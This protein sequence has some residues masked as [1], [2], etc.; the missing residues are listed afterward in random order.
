MS[1]F[2]GSNLWHLNSESARRL[3]SSWN[4]MIQ[5][6]FMNLPFGTHRF[7]LRELSDRPPLQQAL[8]KR[9]SKFCDQIKNSGKP[10]VLQ[11]FHKQK[12]DSRSSFG[13]NYKDI[14]IYKKELT[15]YLTPE[16]DKWKVPVIKELLEVMDKKS[17]ISDFSTDE[18]RCFLAD[19]ACT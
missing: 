2:Y 17:I 16:S 12:Y 18:L 5:T 11:L 13:K 4:S 19:I 14:F 3:Y 10:E 15:E 6:T 9:F 8:N 1:S 7:I